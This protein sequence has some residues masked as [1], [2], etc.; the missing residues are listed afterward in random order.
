MG[1]YCEECSKKGIIAGQAFTNFICG[2]C[3]YRA[4]HENTATPKICIKCSRDTNRCQRCCKKIKSDS[5]K[6]WTTMVC[7]IEISNRT[8]DV[9]IGKILVNSPEIGAAILF[10][11]I[12]IIPCIIGAVVVCKNTPSKA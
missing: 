4:L 1:N 10:T 7:P 2:H 3:F 5:P 11:A 8:A 9:C 6:A 12:V